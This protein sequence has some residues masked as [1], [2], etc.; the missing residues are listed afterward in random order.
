MK[1]AA[2][3]L[4][5][6]L[7]T[8]LAAGSAHGQTVA[9]VVGGRLTLTTSNLD[10]NVKVEMKEAP[11]VARVFGFQ[12][13]ADG[14]AFTGI[15]GVTVN[16]GSG[17]DQVQF[18]IESRL[19]LDIRINTGAGDLESLVLWKILSGGGAVNAGVTYSST[20]SALQ[21]VGVEFDNDNT[22]ASSI[23]INTGNGTDVVAKVLSDDPSTNLGVVFN[24][25]GPKTTVEVVSAAANLNAT[26]RGS[27][28]SPGTDEVKH[29]VSQI[30]PGVVNIVNNVT[31]AGGDDKIEQI[32]SAPGSTTTIRGNVSAG[33]GND[34]VSFVTQG[35]SVTNGL[36][37]SGGDGSDFLSNEV[38]GVWQLSQ[39]LQARV[40]GGRGDDFLILRSDINT[41]RGTGL[42]ND[43]IPVVDGGEGFDLYAA[44]GLIRNCEGRL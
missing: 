38:Q 39:T 12:G 5:L 22:A 37:L 4:S 28:R 6:A 29:V 25:S 17:R 31:T 16:T 11:G 30:R 2:S 32:V 33:T 1:I 43:L 23:N 9:S 35:A 7:A 20:P 18:E 19:S 21:I 40:L 13:I 15:S 36:T 14:T 27:Y 26:L 42:P 8:L 3:S 41:I 34:F 44:F 24:G 10:Q